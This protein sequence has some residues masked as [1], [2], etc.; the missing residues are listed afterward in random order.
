MAS[1][2]KKSTK[3]H[4]VTRAEVLASIDSMAEEVIADVRIIAAVQKHTV[5]HGYDFE[6]WHKL[7]CS[8]GNAT[9]TLNMLCY[10]IRNRGEVAL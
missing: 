2:P 4:K 3:K 5:E 7:D 9:A 8:H 1:K 6:Q 10:R